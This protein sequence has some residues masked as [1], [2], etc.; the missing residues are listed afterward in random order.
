MVIVNTH[1]E[2]Y[3]LPNFIETLLS[4]VLW[5]PS[6]TATTATIYREIF[7]KAAREW[8]EQDLGFVDWQGHDFSMRGLSGIEAAMTS[9][10]GHLLSFSGTDTLPAILG[11][12]M[13]YDA[14]LDTGGSVPATE[15]SVMCAGS[16]DG[17]LETF[18]RLIEDIY[19][20]GIVSIVSDTW[21]LWKVL[22]DYI[23]KLKKSILRRDG[24]IVIRPDSGDPVKILTGDPDSSYGPERAGVLRLLADAMG[25]DNAG[26][27]IKA[28]AIYG[29]SITPERA[30]SIC[31]KTIREVKLSPYNFVLG[32]GSFTYQYV[33]R[34]TYGFAMKATAVER[35]GE[36]IPIFKDPITDDGGKRSH[37]GIPMAYYA[38]GSNCLSCKQGCTVADLTCGAFR[39]VYQDG[40]HRDRDSFETIRRR[41]RNQN[42]GGNK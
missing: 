25:T 35:S 15:H 17:E 26:H 21:D 23:P 32:I 7:K 29:D 22:T 13:H 12:A 16:K 18:R 20:N 31:D 27:I 11:A 9:G 2:F 14:S 28:G 30:Q 10:M 5:Q 36:V 33:T 19:P 3:W 34:D 38:E 24:K 1:P 4:N 40:L 39:H 8:G 37:V 41:T 42:F 6:T